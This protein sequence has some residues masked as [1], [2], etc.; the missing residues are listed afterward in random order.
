MTDIDARPETEPEEPSDRRRFL[1]KGAVAAAVA[2]AGVAIAR[3]AEAANG[4]NFVLGNN[5]NNATND[6][7]VTGSQFRFVRSTG[8]SVQGT[9]GNGTGVYGL[10]GDSAGGGIGVRGRTNNSGIGV[11]GEAPSTSS[12]GTGVKGTSGIGAGVWGEGG[13]SSV[14][15]VGLRGSSSLGASLLLDETG[16]TVPP[17]SGSWQRG[18]FLNKGGQLWYCYVAGTGT[19]SKW[20]K[21]S[22]APMILGTSY[23]AYD[24]RAGFAPLGVT[25]GKLTEGQTRTNIDLKVNGGAEAIPIGISA[26]IVNLTATNTSSAGFLGIF[27]NGT[28][29]PGTSTV[30]WFATNSSIA[31]SAIV[32]V[33][34]QSRVS[35]RCAGSAD[36]II[37]V[38]GFMP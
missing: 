5:S 25:K 20:V 7:V 27:K 9:N 12:S 35:V 28:V 11:L 33:D 10:S 21:V 15:G 29:W 4:S 16:I 32:A 8:I 34:A 18:S 13:T 1:T 26:A 31:N 22:G 38:I 37:D 30:N 2:A 14:R 6:T 36:F 24:S 3:P 19:A 17:V 23:R